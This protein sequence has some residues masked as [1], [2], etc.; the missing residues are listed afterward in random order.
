MTIFDT[1][2]VSLLFL[3]FII[4][5]A[6]AAINIATKKYASAIANFLYSIVALVAAILAIVTKSTMFMS[7]F[8]LAFAFGFAGLCYNDY[9]EG[10]SGSAILEAILTF[11]C[12]TCFLITCFF[13]IIG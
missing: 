9:K 6:V 3:S 1:F 10:N 5:I 8:I 4:F 7:Y 2:F 12:L 11:I 13:A